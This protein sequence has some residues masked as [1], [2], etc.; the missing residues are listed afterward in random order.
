MKA[1][2]PSFQKIVPLKFNS[3]CVAFCH[4]AITAMPAF[5]IQEGGQV[6]RVEIWAD[7]LERVRAERGMQM[8]CYQ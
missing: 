1:Q 5:F 4:N 6:K 8:S 3:I 7:F 2:R